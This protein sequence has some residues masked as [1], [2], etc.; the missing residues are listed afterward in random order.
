MRVALLQSF[1]PSRSQGGVGHFT[2]QF[3]NKLAERGHEVTVFSLDPA[4]ADAAYAVIQADAG[5]WYLRGRLGAL[6]GFAVWLA[7]Q[8]Y[9]RFDVVH[10]LGDNYLIGPRTPI[11]RTIS[12]A[13][14][15]EAAH[16]RKLITKLMYLTIY[17]LELAGVAL[18]RE[19]VGIS[20]DSNKYF[21]WVRNVIPQGVDT[22]LFRPGGTRSEHPSILFVG[23]RFRD[24]KRAFLLHDA[25]QQVV[26]PALPEA[27]LWLVCDD[28]I[29]APGVQ[30]FSNLP[31]ETLA[32]LFRTA[33]VFCLPSS[34]EG[35]GRP[36]AEA[37]ASGTP[38]VATPNAGALE[39][40]N[41]G[42][43]GL[44]TPPGT[45]G[46]ALLG[47]LN[48]ESR[49]AAMAK[50]GLTR[51]AHYDWQRV[52]DQY[53]ALYGRLSN[54]H[55]VRQSIPPSIDTAGATGAAATPAVGPGERG[56]S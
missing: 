4:P 49:R 3:A 39:V 41:R 12:G 30:G 32:E 19:A 37:L 17:P 23:H 21:P 29:D 6:Y 28:H 54:G 40:L 24:R 36:Y 46:T 38:V 33:W 44:I 13:A 11:V 43:F 5:E 8:D 18:A 51:A 26:R 52:V 53:E 20:H 42:E 31:I 55:R 48:D 47:L 56:A 45:L 7:R 14:L 15:A 27:E 50:H 16:A 34:Y 10:A 35:F 25:F 2:H 1:L 22:A 9:R